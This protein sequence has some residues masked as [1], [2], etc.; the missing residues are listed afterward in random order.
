MDG[1]P[2]IGTGC[3]GVISVRRQNHLVSVALAR[4]GLH[5]TGNGTVV[6]ICVGRSCH[7]SIVQQ[8]LPFVFGRYAPFVSAVLV[9]D[10][11]FFGNGQIV[12]VCH[13]TVQCIDFRCR[14]GGFHSPRVIAARSG[15]TCG[16]AVRLRVVH[17]VFRPYTGITEIDGFGRE[18]N[19]TAG[20]GSRTHLIDGYRGALESGCGCYDT[21]YYHIFLP[22]A[23]LHGVA[24]H[25]SAKP[26]VERIAGGYARA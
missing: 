25:Q 13:R 14:S 8:C 3:P 1:I 22:F 6:V 21:C 24:V 4:E 11:R 9:G 26:A 10:I 20:A 15:F 2:E 19:D 23:E 7:S 16:K 17:I 5:F 12:S 18:R